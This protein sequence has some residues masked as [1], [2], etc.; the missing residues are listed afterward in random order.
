[1]YISLTDKNCLSK[2]ENGKYA[3]K[4]TQLLRRLY[5]KEGKKASDQKDINKAKNGTKKG[6]LN[7][8]L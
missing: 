4:T 8:R 6:V 1:M 5:Q 2:R 3:F 7:M